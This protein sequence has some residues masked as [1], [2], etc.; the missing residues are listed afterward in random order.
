MSSNRGFEASRKIRTVNEKS[1]SQF[2]ST[3]KTSISL[4]KQLRYFV[5]SKKRYLAPVL[6][7]K[8]KKKKTKIYSVEIRIVQNSKISK[9]LVYVLNNFSCLVDYTFSKNKFT[10][11][12]ILTNFMKLFILFPMF[13][14]RWTFIFSQILGSHFTLYFE[15]FWLEIGF[16]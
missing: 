6:G 13:R 3:Q 15:H 12:V 4:K 9:I 8:S 1:C 11:K 7:L 2:L 5:F 14:R 16:K 10:L